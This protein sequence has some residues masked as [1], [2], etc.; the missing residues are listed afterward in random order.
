ME[1]HGKDLCCEKRG[2]KGYVL[3]DCPEDGVARE[4]SRV[5]CSMLTLICLLDSKMQT[6]RRAQIGRRLVKMG[7]AHGGKIGQ[8]SILSER[9][10]ARECGQT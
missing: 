2:A 10:E 8:E 6:Y 9:K 5:V 1:P 4:I 3:R 7:G